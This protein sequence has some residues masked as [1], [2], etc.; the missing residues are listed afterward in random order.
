MKIAVVFDTLR[1]G[2][3]HA[4]FKEELEAEVA[5]AEYEVAEALIENGHDVFLLGFHDNLR[6]LLDRLEDF[7]PDL[8]FNAT[9]SFMGKARYDY[10]VTALLE[11]KGYRYTGSP[12]EALL[13]AR[14]KATSKK[15]LE[16]HSINIPR[17]AVYPVDED[18]EAPEIGYPLIV[19][20]THED[21]SVGI[22]QSSVVGDYDSLRERV[23]FIH[24]SLNQPAIAEELIDGRELYVG[25]IGNSRPEILPII[26]VVF[27]KVDAAEK[28]I[29][30][31]SAKW[32]LDYRKRWGIKNIFAR[33]IGREALDEIQRAAKQA[34]SALE[35]RDYGRIDFRLTRDQKAYVIEVNPNP[36][37]A[38]GEDM[39]NSAE[40]AGM[41]Y[42][43]FIERIVREAL[44]RYEKA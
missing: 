30:T 20:P 40:R 23:E 43:A 36:Y 41:D 29:A 39:A 6:R 18:I 19:K 10:G 16:Y 7:Q 14:D 24:R 8:V 25:V 26:E 4:D 17:F 34:Y 11:M 33:R 21:A 27:D 2:W 13:L 15:I 28:R 31:Y 9:E 44:T 22:A 1:S 5:E 32:D 42:N 37:L 35:L 3:E 12:P 38:F